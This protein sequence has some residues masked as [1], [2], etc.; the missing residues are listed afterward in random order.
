MIAVILQG[1]TEAERFAAIHN[2]IG[3][4]AMIRRKGTVSAKLGG[5]FLIPINMREGS[6][7]CTVRAATV[8]I[9]QVFTGQDT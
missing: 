1:L 3:T 4:E 8:G 5:Q 9:S 6:L 7:I 2:Y